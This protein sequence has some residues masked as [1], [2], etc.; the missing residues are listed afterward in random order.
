MKIQ[1]ED[2]EPPLQNFTYLSYNVAKQGKEISYQVVIPKAPLSVCLEDVKQAIK[3][4]SLEKSGNNNNEFYYFKTK[5]S[6]GNIVEVVVNDNSEPIPLLDGMVVLVNKN[7]TYVS[8]TLEEEGGK[9]TKYVAKI[10]KAPTC[11]RLNDVND[12]RW[13]SRGNYNDR[14]RD[15]W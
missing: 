11:V 4:S 8:Y 9:E 3:W 10:P 1:I 6:E 13:D 7:V 2:I 12:V 15:R 5:D 14:L